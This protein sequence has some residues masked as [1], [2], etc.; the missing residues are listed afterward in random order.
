MQSNCNN[1]HPS[2]LVHRDYLFFSFLT[3]LSLPIGFST[4][5]CAV[6]AYEKFTICKFR[7]VIIDMQIFAKFNS[8]AGSN[9]L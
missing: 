3:C 7:G 2:I 8:S 6:A 4:S 5:V 1:N 9:R